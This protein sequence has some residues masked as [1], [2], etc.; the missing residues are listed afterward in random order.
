MQCNCWSRPACGK[1]VSNS[2]ANLHVE[3]G[4]V[5]V[6]KLILSGCLLCWLWRWTWRTVSMTD[7]LTDCRCDMKLACFLCVLGL[8][9]CR[10][11]Y[12]KIVII[13][14][15][16]SCLYFIA[17]RC[18]AMSVNYDVCETLYSFLVCSRSVVLMPTISSYGRER[19]PQPHPVESKFLNWSARNLHSWHPIWGGLGS[20]VE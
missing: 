3:T 6:V 2:A 14:Y 20:V 9:R 15:C 12:W 11:T 13:K 4:D 16:S 5:A 1:L 17:W 7:W 18:I 19:C 10:L 8:F